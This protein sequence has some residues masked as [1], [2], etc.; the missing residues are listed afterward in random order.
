MLEYSLLQYQ[1]SVVAASAILLAQ[2]IPTNFQALKIRLTWE[3]QAASQ[4]RTGWGSRV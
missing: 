2:V 4:T 1:P 3:D